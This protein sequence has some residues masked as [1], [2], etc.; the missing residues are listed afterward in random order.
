M[1][2]AVNGMQQALEMA[3]GSVGFTALFLAGMLSLWY[4][5]YEN[6][7]ETGY[8]FWYA[9]IML[10]ILINPFYIAFI[11]RYAP[12]LAK[13]NI[14]LWILPVVP[15]IICCAVRAVGILENWQ[16]KIMFAVGLV[17]LLVLAAATSYS[18]SNVSIR[19]NSNST[20]AERQ[21]FE[22]LSA[23]LEASGASGFLIWGENTIMESARIYDGR[24]RLIYGKDMWMSD[25]LALTGT[26]YSDELV[27]A[28][29]GMNSEL[30]EVNVLLDIAYSY[31]CDAV[32]LY[33]EKIENERIVFEN[34]L[35][36]KREEFY[37][38]YQ[39]GHFNY[40]HVYGELEAD[41]ETEIRENDYYYP[42]YETGKY[43][44]Y[45]RK[46]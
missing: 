18:A 5:K 2:S 34:T 23:E 24:F 22:Y 39:P 44:V 40:G 19:K 29:N 27:M 20:E 46:D 43:T 41:F 7:P 6:K 13:N 32:V 12:S 17:A 31:G 15:V 14:F 36:Q 33:S 30:I 11:N 38:N 3:G 25:C 37:A 4:S 45:L 9:L 16:K 1:A 28:Y 8:L 26:Q 10:I 21:V 42:A 35:E